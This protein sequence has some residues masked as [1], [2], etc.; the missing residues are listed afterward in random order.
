MNRH[1]DKNGAVRPTTELVAVV[2]EYEHA[3]LHVADD[4]DTACA[5]CRSLAQGA[6]DGHNAP[7]FLDIAR[8][9]GA[10]EQTVR[11]AAAEW[12]HASG[13]YENALL[14]GDP[15]ARQAA[16]RH[17]AAAHDTYSRALRR[18]VADPG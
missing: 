6:L 10:D 11:D 14:S 17:L 13:D 5:D 8:D 15:A 2:L 9:T 3:L 4:H 12:A 7:D 18:A 16:A 1:L